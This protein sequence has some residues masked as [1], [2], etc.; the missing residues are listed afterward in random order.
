MNSNG[1]IRIMKQVK[2]EPTPPT[3]KRPTPK[4]TARLGYL[5]GRKLTA[6]QQAEHDALFTR[7]TEWATFRGQGGDPDAVDARR[8]KRIIPI[9]NRENKRIKPDATKHRETVAQRTTNRKHGTEATKAKAE[10]NRNEIKRLYLRYKAENPKWKKEGLQRK[11]AETHPR[12]RG[13]SLRSIKA[14]TKD[15]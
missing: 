15:L 1:T 12:K 7:W 6:K 9:Q 13:F 10:V 2:T 3:S 11:V 8:A 14:A 4:E 5:T